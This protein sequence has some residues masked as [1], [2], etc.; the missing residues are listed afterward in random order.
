MSTETFFLFSY[1]TTHTTRSL[2]TYLRR[3]CTEIIFL[4]LLP[5][6]QNKSIKTLATH[7]RRICTEM[8]NFAMKTEQIHRSLD[9]HLRRMSTEMLFLFSHENKTNTQIF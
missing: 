1:E 3:I 7:L 9:T 2:E 6:K 8:I 4:L 5:P